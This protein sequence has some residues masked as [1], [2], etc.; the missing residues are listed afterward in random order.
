MTGGGTTGSRGSTVTA[1]G[2][3][4]L[5]PGGRRP[6]P[7]RTSDDR[8][9]GNG[10]GRSTGPASAG[11]SGVPRLPA[12]RAGPCSYDGTMSGRGRGFHLGLP[13]LGIPR[14]HRPAE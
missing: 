10:V 13:D 1:S 6:L 2:E 12:A 9:P 3:P 7:W 5:R 11:P 4:Q 14:V 8:R